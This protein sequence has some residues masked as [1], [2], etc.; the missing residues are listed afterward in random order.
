MG[1]AL[2]LEN[3]PAMREGSGRYQRPFLDNPSVEERSIPGAEGAPEVKV[4]VINAEAGKSKPAMLHIHGGGFILGTASAS[5]AEMQALALKHDCVVVTVDYRLAPETPFPGALDDNYAALQWLHD[6]AETLGVDPSRI[7]VMGDSAGGG[8]AA[9]LAIA[10]RDR[11]EI[12][13]V[14]QILIYPMLDDRTGSTIERPYWMG[15]LSWSPEA[16]R[17]GWSSLLGVPAGADKV[18]YGSVPARVEDLSGLP[19]TFIAVGSVDLFVDEDI[20]YARRL[21]N[22]G[23]PT[24]LAVLPGGFHGFQAMAPESALARR[25]NAATDAAIARAFNP[26]DALPPMPQSFQN[27]SDKKE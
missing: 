10:A 25:F 8:H 22:A 9:M 15:H 1:G 2:T 12:P 4:Y 7:A 21:I 26:P 16:N 18:P 14:A 6:N 27:I 23:V 11:G 13:L 19:A 3:L 24:E 5:V 20:E 17:L